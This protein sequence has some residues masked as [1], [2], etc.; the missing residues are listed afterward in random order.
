MSEATYQ[1]TVQKMASER[2]SLNNYKGFIPE[3]SEVIDNV[4][5]NRP[6]WRPDSDKADLSLTKMTPEQT[7]RYIHTGKKPPGLS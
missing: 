6:P 2:K 7:T 5:K 1:E 3:G 4:V